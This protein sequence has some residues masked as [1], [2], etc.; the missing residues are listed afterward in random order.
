MTD[1]DALVRAICESPDDDTPRLIF[2]D[3]LEESG[4]AARAEFVRSQVELARTPDWE[5][6]AVLCR[7]RRTEWSEAGEPFRNALPPLGPDVTWHDQPFRRGLGWRVNV[8]NLHVWKDIAP[9]LYERAPVGELH[10]NP[11]AT[12]DDW[13]EFASGEWVKWFRVIHLEGGSPVEPIR[14]LCE[15]P[16]A[17]GITDIHFHVA[18]SPGLPE[19]VED[20]LAT[21]LGRGLKGLHFS[22]GYQ[23]L[24]PL[25]DAIA[26]SKCSFDR[27]SFHTM[28]LTADRL[29][30]LLLSESA[31]QLKELRLSNDRLSSGEPD[32]HPAWPEHLPETLTTLRINN[33]FLRY[34]DL[35]LLNTGQRHLDLKRLELTMDYNLRYSGDVFD[36]DFLTRLRSLSLR[37]TPM[38]PEAWRRL[39]QSRPWMNLVHLDIRGVE[40]G[41]AAV[42]RLVQAPMPPDLVAI[43]IDAPAD[44]AHRAALEERYGERL[45]VEDDPDL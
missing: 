42:R 40:L 11:A 33:G 22:V 43:Q 17:C 13:I 8:R 19:L 25:V 4:E 35:D 37:D 32:D 3:F 44:P 6:F 39:V 21:P 16:D 7:T 34:G 23:S 15:S 2:A 10:L 27:L 18:T 30:R 14:A 31:E 36:S 26:D 9:R 5:P 1:H 28:G 20:L 12:R 38:L 29:D 41:E 45:V 24:D